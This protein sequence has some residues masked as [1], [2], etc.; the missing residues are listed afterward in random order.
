MK[1]LIF[2]L[3]ASALF[4]G[5]QV[6]QVSAAT[7]APTEVDQITP[8]ISLGAKGKAAFDY[9]AKSQVLTLKAISGGKK[10]KAVLRITSGVTG[11][12]KEI[13]VISNRT[14]EYTFDMERLPR[15]TFE[16]TLV[17]NSVNATYR[18]ER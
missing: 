1:K 3:A 15:G 13:I 17:S 2:T 8:G 10:E 7:I 9:D 18:F 16:V 12:V 14:M 11:H 4:F 5:A 6:E